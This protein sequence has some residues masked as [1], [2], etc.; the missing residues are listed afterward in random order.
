MSMKQKA[1]FHMSV[2]NLQERDHQT[3]RS[4]KCSFDYVLGQRFST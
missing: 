3:G 1:S 2:E 4:P